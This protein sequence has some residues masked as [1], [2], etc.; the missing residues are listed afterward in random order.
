MTRSWWDEVP[1]AESE[2]QPFTMQIETKER[3]SHPCGFI[4]LKERHKVKASRHPVN[5][6][7]RRCRI[8]RVKLK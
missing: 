7:D 3:F 5:A 1:Y 6:I 4:T 8:V 2:Q